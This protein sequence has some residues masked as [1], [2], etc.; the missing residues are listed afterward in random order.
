MEEEE[1]EERREGN[2]YDDHSRRRHRLAV[3]VT[4][5]VVSFLFRRRAA[6]EKLL[7]SLLPF[8]FLFIFLCFH[9]EKWQSMNVHI[10]WLC[11]YFSGLSVCVCVWFTI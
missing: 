11:Q 10:D 7:V 8:S 1:K 3:K 5:A 6:G 4:F 9:F 2:L